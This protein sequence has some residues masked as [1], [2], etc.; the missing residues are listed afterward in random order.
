MIGYFRCDKC[1]LGTFYDGSIM[2]AFLFYNKYN[3][4]ICSNC[5]FIHNDPKY[6]RISPRKLNL[7]AEITQ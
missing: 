6:W 2:R 5:K 3:Q 7:A 1:T 4:L